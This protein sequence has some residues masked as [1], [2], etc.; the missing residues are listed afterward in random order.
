MGAA[1]VRVGPIATVALFVSL[2]AMNVMN[3]GTWRSRW[4][5]GSSCPDFFRG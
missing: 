2:F 5:V 3:G 1:I 4:S